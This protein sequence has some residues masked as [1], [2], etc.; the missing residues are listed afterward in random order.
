MRTKRFSVSSTINPLMK[1]Q[2][3]KAVFFVDATLVAAYHLPGAVMTRRI[4]PTARTSQPVATPPRPPVIPRTSNATTPSAFQVAGV[5]TTRTIVVMVAMNSIAKC[6]TVPKA[7]SVAALAS[8]SSMTSVA[9]VKYI[10][11][12]AATRSTATSPAKRISSS[13][14]PSTP[15]SI[16]ECALN[17]E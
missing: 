17:F 15:A 6:A 11:M 8:A 5:A 9:M 7:N 1:V 12:T 13:A 2:I 14:P 10:A 16:S 3:T 4:V